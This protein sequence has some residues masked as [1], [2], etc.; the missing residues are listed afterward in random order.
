MKKVK[1]ETP[2]RIAKTH[3]AQG[4]IVILAD[5]GNFRAV[6]WADNA[7]RRKAIRQWMHEICDGT[8]QGYMSTDNRMELEQAFAR[9]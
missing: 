9:K 5:N 2:M 4:A 3:E 8:E 7:E 1:V 6:A